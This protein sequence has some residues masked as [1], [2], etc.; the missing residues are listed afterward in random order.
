ML[1]ETTEAVMASIRKEI[2]INAPAEPI[3]DALTRRG[4]AAHETGA[5]VS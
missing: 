1:R 5:R 3:W 2:R 4:R